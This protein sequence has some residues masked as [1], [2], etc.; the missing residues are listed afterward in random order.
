M[1]LTFTIQNFLRNKSK[2]NTAISEKHIFQPAQ[3]LNNKKVVVAT[4]ESVVSTDTFIASS[5]SSCEEACTRTRA[6]PKMRFETSIDALMEV[7]GMALQKVSRDVEE[8][9]EDVTLLVEPPWKPPKQHLML[10]IWVVFSASSLL[11]GLIAGAIR[12]LID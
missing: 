12:E 7:A 11:L 10:P 3:H 8:L 9:S 6:K 4:D 1:M 5:S 2:N